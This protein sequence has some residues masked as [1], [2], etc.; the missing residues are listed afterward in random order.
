MSYINVII[1]KVMDDII[2]TGIGTDQF[3]KHHS[4]FY[5]P[6]IIKL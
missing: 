3:N 1:L 2:P 5:T 6:S 4:E